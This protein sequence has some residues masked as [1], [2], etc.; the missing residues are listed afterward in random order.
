VDKVDVMVWEY[1]K[2]L[3]VNPS[4]LAEGLKAQQAELERDSVLLRERLVVVDDLLDE[5]QQ[6]L[7][8]LLDLY[9]RGDFPQEM[10]TERKARLEGTIE[11]LR[12]ERRDLAAQIESV[13]L[14][15]ERL[16]NI[17]EFAGQV[18]QGLKA[19]DEHFEIRQQI[20]EELDVQVTVAVEQDEKVLYVR[21]FVG[22]SR[23]CLESTSTRDESADV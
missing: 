4:T 8:R 10:L 23:Q 15:D 14:S 3:L 11:S 21:C 18:A 7:D 19:A 1:I 17:T 13:T 9:L 6:Q 12:Q 20:I 16:T 22:E 2:S 5:N